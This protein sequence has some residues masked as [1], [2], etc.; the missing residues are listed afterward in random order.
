MGKVVKRQIFFVFPRF[1]HVTEDIIWV[2]HLIW[3]TS[4]NEPEQKAYGG[5]TYG[6]TDPSAGVERTFSQTAFF[7][8]LK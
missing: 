4:L 7:F 2:H 1:F 8:A 5:M 6:R 3:V